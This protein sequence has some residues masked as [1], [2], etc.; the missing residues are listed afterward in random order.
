MTVQGN[1]QPQF[2]QAA[3]NQSV[4]FGSAALA[5][6]DGSS[7]TIGTN[8]FLLYTPGANDSYVEAIRIMA[9]A[10]TASSAT[11]ATT[12]RVYRST[13]NSGSTST[14]NTH[15]IWE[16]ALPSITADA[17]TAATNWVDVPL[18]MRFAGSNSATPEYILISAHVINASNTTFDATA[19]GSNY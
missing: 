12:V 11:S 2:T 8:I 16:G 7:G 13:V 6:S 19:F 4:K 17:P 18:G 5:T 14:S 10:S 1:T 9:T 3:N 15:L